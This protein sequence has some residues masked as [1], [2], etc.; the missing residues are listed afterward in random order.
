MSMLAFG[1]CTLW[2]VGVFGALTTHTF[3]H[4]RHTTKCCNIIRTTG[5][6]VI[7]AP[8]LM[9]MASLSAYFA[10]EAYRNTWWEVMTY[11]HKE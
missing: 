7:F 8:I 2:L 4:I 5:T 3:N 1:T 11:D 10:V 6:Y 9:L